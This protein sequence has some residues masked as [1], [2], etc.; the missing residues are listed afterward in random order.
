L[1]LR[2]RNRLIAASTGATIVVEAG[3]RSGSLNTA[4]H[5]A[6]IGRPLGAVPG[7]VT[8]AESAGCHRLLREYDATCI[9][10]PAEALELLGLTEGAL[11]PAS[12]MSESQTRVLD[13]VHRRHPR[14]AAEIAVAAG[15]SVPE[16]LGAL[17]VL[18][19]DGLVAPVLDGGWVRA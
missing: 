14:T 5:A 15:M 4:G 9:T 10:T 16:V 3:R 6:A 18:E 7:R 11:P 12:R 17:A 2:Q 1:T 19:V 8:S 13:A